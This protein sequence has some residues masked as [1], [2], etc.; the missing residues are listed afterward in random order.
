M[1]LIIELTP[2]EQWAARQV[3]V[4]ITGSQNKLE[5]A[6]REL[7]DANGLQ[8]A[9]EAY[10]ASFVEAVLKSH[11]KQDPGTSPGLE[12][13][14]A[15]MRLV[16]EKPPPAP[17]PTVVTPAPPPDPKEPVKADAS[18]AKKAASGRKGTKP[19]AKKKKAKRHG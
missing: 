16:W 15:G 6:Q 12:Q 9:A 4:S 18:P 3:Q 11:Q 7:E 2:S 1:S 14:K 5:K 10:R 8:Q 19:K 13:S 17:K